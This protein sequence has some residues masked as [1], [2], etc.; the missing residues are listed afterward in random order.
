LGREVGEAQSFGDCVAIRTE[1]EMPIE[2]MRDENHR[3]WAD[4]KVIYMRVTEQT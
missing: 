4:R 1:R 2:P 3:V